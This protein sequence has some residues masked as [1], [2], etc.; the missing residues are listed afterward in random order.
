MHGTLGTARALAVAVHERTAGVACDVVVCPPAVH[1]LAVSQALSDSHVEVG[2]QDVSAHGPGAWTGQVAAGMLTD[3]GCAWTIVGHSERRYDCAES[4]ELVS[5]KARA[6]LAAGLKVIACIGETL[7]QRE[8]GFTAEVIAAQMLPLLELCASSP[9]RFV[10]AY[11][12]VWAIGT[13]LSASAEQAQ[14]VHAGV[15][16]QVAAAWPAAADALRILY[17]GSVSVAVAPGLFAMPDID[18]ALVGGASLKA[19]DFSA[20]CASALQP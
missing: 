11:E 14:E 17:G 6:A 5:R 1:L 9:G 2:A 12:P 10:V 15:R 7:A 19:E 13:G 8:A 20:I 18:G 16:A 4:D 3:A